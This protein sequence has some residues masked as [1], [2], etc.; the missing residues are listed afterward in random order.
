MKLCYLQGND[1]WRQIILNKLTML[2]KTNTRM[3]FSFVFPRFY[4]DIEIH[5]YNI[6][7]YIYILFPYLS[8]Y[9]CMCIINRSVYVNVLLT[10]ELT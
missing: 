1:N 6:Y 10:E 2:I 5:I 8:I 9:V 7:T 3:F 4:T